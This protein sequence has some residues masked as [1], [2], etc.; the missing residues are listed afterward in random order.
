[1]FVL[2]FPNNVCRQLSILTGN[3]CREP[4]AQLTAKNPFVVYMFV[5]RALPPLTASTSPTANQPL[6]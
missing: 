2:F 6:P 5:V 4:E 3:V 1:M